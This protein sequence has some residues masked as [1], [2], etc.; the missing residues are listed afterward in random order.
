MSSV[1]G[2][3]DAMR[4]DEPL[5]DHLCFPK[6]ISGRNGGEARTKSG[7][8]QWHQSVGLPNLGRILTQRQVRADLIVTC[9]IRKKNLPQARFAKDQYPVQAHAAHGANRR[10][11][12]GFCYG[13]PGEIAVRGLSRTNEPQTRHVRDSGALSV[14]WGLRVHGPLSPGHAL[15]AEVCRHWPRRLGGALAPGRRMV[16]GAGVP[17]SPVHVGGYS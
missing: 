11:T 7:W 17:D 1:N 9:H 4:C 3:T 12:Y 10:S 6:I 5:L 15:V 14:I 8:R 16:R 13:D 2:P